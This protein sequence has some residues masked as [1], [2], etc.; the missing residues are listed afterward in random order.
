M[1]EIKLSQIL[2][3]TNAPFA[4]DLTGLSHT[5]TGEDGRIIRPLGVCSIEYVIAGKGYVTENDK[6]FTVRAGDVFILHEDQYHDYYADKNDPWMKIWVQVSGPAAPDI[7]RAYGL[8]KINHIRDF[9]IKDDIFR[10]D[11]RLN[12]EYVVFNIKIS[13]MIDL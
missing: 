8:S 11:Y 6:T 2:K 3:K 12:S 1:S 5:S 13:Y 9:D 4:I 10:I 7:L